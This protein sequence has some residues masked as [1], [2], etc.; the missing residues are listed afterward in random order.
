MDGAMGG[1]TDRRTESLI[2]VLR[3]TLT[4]TDTRPSVACGWAEA[5][6]LKNLYENVTDG[7]TG[8]RTDRRTHPL[9]ESLARD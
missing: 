1:W 4:R 6:L 5:V 7:P 3:C 9:K 8:R 2:E